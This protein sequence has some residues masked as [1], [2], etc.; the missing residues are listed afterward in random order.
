LIPLAAIIILGIIK[1]E[2]I[3]SKWDG[4]F[5]SPVAVNVSSNPPYNELPETVKPKVFD[6]I[7]ERDTVSSPIEETDTASFRRDEQT[8]KPEEKTTVKEKAASTKKYYIVAGSFS[9]EKNAENLVKKLKSKGYNSEIF[10]QTSKG[11]LMVS[12][13][14][15][16]SKKEALNVL[17]KLV[18]EENP[19]AWLIHY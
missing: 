14:N 19:N 1:Y 5:N 9:L 18:R 15:F 12:Y 3:R 10:G 2:F 4:Y 17:N 6:T 11:L 7:N 13:D 8:T 16:I